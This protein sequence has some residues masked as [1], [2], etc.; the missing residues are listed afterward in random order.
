MGDKYRVRVIKVSG[1]ELKRNY[2]CSIHM[3]DGRPYRLGLGPGERCL[4]REGIPIEKPV[5]H[6]LTVRF[7]VK[8]RGKEGLNN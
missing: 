3:E 8:V 5:S 7:E 1:D 4:V 2:K 6:G